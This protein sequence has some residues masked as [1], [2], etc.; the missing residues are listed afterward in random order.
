MDLMHGLLEKQ[1]KGLHFSQVLEVGAHNGEHLPYVT[2]TFDT[3][4]L[5]D[6]Q[7]MSPDD[8]KQ[9]PKGVE[10]VVA[11]LESLP[12]E[13]STFDRVLSTCVLHHV[14]KLEDAIDE[15]LRVCKPGGVI[16]ILLPTDPGLTY[17]WVKF[18][19][20]GIKAKKLGLFEQVKLFHAREHRNHYH[21]IAVI[22]RAKLE[23]HPI[24]VKF[25]PFRVPSWN[26]NALTIWEIHK[27]GHN[28]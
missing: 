11:N 12:F 1:H 18:L 3:Y 21:S 2:H 20:S 4:T 7:L 16:S 24:K 15:L 6:I 14:S 25:W 17:R 8:V 27:A 23:P 13:N 10:F 9:L 26:L 19:G 22:L 28:D 5:S